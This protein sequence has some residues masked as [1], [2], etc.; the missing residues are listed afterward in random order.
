MYKL[1]CIENINLLHHAA[2]FVPVNM[3]FRA[4]F[5]E[6]CD[7]VFNVSRET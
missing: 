6:E 1:E 7:G 3:G 5:K 2:I 4:I